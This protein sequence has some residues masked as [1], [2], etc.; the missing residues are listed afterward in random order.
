LEDLLDLAAKEGLHWLKAEVAADQRQAIQAF[1]NRGFDLTMVL[2]H[3]FCD[4]HGATRDAVLLLCAL[5]DH[6]QGIW[7]LGVTPEADIF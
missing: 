1:L 4:P 5:Q 3:Y 6:R 2:D 7:D